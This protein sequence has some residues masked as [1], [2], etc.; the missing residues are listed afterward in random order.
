MWLFLRTYNNKSVIIN[1]KSLIDILQEYNKNS[2]KNLF[3]ED[4]MIEFLK[5]IIS[6]QAYLLTQMGLELNYLFEMLLL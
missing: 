2:N 4:L 1:T 5:G 3:C 6:L